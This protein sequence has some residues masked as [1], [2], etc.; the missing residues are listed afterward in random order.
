MILLTFLGLQ[1]F[2][3]TFAPM[4]VK[5]QLLSSKGVV[6]GEVLSTTSLRDPKFGIVTKAFIRAD[7]W[8]GTDVS[9]G[10]VELFF[11]GGSLGEEA[12]RVPGAPRFSIGEKV[13]VFTSS[14]ENKNWVYNL[15]L[16]K[17]SLKKVGTSFVMVNQV[18]P[19]VPD[20]GQMVFR[21][22]VDMAQRLKGEKFQKRFKDKYERAVENKASHQI[23]SANSRSIASASSSSVQVADENS[24]FWLVLLL[25]AMG[26][27]FRL[28]SRKN[29]S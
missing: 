10:H 2:A 6:Q 21:N 19:Q 15:G 5:D 9:N 3:T 22:F 11:P 26:F 23:K 16:G 27:T 28:S 20:V 7:M 24:S 14:H 29:K 25:G 13:V 17:F 12:R 4:S 18:F 8:M 1:C